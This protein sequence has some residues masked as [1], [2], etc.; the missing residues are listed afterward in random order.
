MSCTK[1]GYTSLPSHTFSLLLVPPPSS[2]TANSYPPS[3]IKPTGTTVTV[4]CT[5]TLSWPIYDTS[6]AMTIHLI[7][8]EGNTLVLSST[9]VSSTVHFVTAEIAEFQ[10]EHSGVYN[11]T[12]TI[13]SPLTVDRQTML[14][15]ADIVIGSGK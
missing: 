13:E 6:V 1:R 10:R 14:G 3:P 11:C 12:A 5:V 4:N 7:D 15:V 9:S 8:P 2:V